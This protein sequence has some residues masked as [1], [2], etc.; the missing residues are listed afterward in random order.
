M[1]K[2]EEAVELATLAVEELAAFESFLDL[3][4]VNGFEPKNDENNV[5]FICL[6]SFTVLVT[7]LLKLTIEL[8]AFE[9]LTISSVE[10]EDLLL[11]MD[12]ESIKLDFTETSK[13][14]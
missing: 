1:N 14:K 4:V 10:S 5:V 12:A 8:E 3:F 2:P 7:R 9:L 6:T 13:T 11:F